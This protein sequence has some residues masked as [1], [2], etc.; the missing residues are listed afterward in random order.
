MTK[1]NST[2]A[3]SV[4][5][6]P[7]E[8]WKPVPGIPKYEVSNFGRVVTDRSPYILKPEID[9]DG[10]ER[11]RLHI[12]S[13]KYLKR[14]VHKLVLEAFVGEAPVGHVPAHDNGVRNDNRL[15][16]LSWKTQRANISDK[17]GHGTHQV[18]SKHP[19]ATIDG[20]TATR[21]KVLLAQGVKPRFIA[22]ELRI[23]RQIV[24]SIKYG[25]AWGH[26]HD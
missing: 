9:R 8:I 20:P 14:G 26:N 13:Q 19:N 11:V 23:S 12:G 16:N 18:G 2:R 10:Y 24:Y 3:A 17:I 21:V 5:V 7:G 1:R 6:R 22:L 15:E 25:K 4:D